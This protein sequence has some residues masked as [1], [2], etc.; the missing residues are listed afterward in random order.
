MK[1]GWALKMLG[2]STSAFVTESHELH[3]IR[4]SVIAPYL[5]KA[6]VQRLEPAVQLV[7]DKLVSRFRDIQGRDT[8]VNLLYP[9]SALAADVVGQYSFAR[10]F[11]FMDR[12]DYGSWLYELMMQVSANS[13]VFKHFGWVEPLMRRIPPWLNKLID[14][15]L[16]SL[17]I[18]E[19]VLY[20]TTQQWV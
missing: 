11:G 1:Y 10:P 8:A 9:F 7:V 5:S 18:M 19:N 3:R 12:S 4:R 17:V 15:K 6:S 14:P 2:Q 16:A 13:H 20:D